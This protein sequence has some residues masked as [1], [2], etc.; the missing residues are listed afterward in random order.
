VTKKIIKSP[1]LVFFE[2]KLHLENCPNGKVDKVL[3]VKMGISPKLEVEEL[4]AKGDASE[5][6][7]EEPNVEDESKAELPAAK[8]T[9]RAETLKLDTSKD[10]PPPQ[11]GNEIVGNSRYLDRPC[12]PLGK[13][14]KNHI[15]QPQDNEYA[16]ITIVGEPKNFREAVESSDASE[17]K[18]AIQ[19]EYEFLIANATWELAPLPK[20]RKAVKCK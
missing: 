15:P 19:E 6:E 10:T 2:D 17:W 1:D 14:R 4:E 8:S 16:N 13:W 7:N 18:L 5:P 3:V 11:Y 9:R 20:G 12:T